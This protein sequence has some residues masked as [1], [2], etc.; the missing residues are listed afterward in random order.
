MKIS[1]DATLK[2]PVWAEMLDRLVNNIFKTNWDV[3][4]LC[5]SIGMMYDQQIESDELVPSDYTENPRYI[6]RLVLSEHK[7][8][9]LLEFMLQAALITTK[10]VDLSEEQRLEYAFSEEA[11]VPFNSL[12]F[13]TKYANYGITKLQEVLGDAEDVELMEKIMTFLNDTYENGY[14]PTEGLELELDD[15]D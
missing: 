12:N 9:S 13:L 7:R 2:G 11:E 10:H 1:T 15:F 3:Y 4:S 14:D 5:I 8:K 6:P